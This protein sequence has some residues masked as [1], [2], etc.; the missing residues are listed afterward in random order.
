MLKR[1]INHESKRIDG[2]LSKLPDD[3]N[4]H[5][6]VR[7]NG[8]EFDADV[9]EVV[10][11]SGDIYFMEISEILLIQMLNV[12]GAIQGELRYKEYETH[13]MYWGG[14]ELW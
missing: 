9:D 3:I 7:A 12:G 1:R 11:E 4:V 8:V 2:K 5:I 13:A 6:E 10:Y 14:Y